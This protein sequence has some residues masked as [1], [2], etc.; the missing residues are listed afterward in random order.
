MNMIRLTGIA[1]LACAGLVAAGA[2]QAQTAVANDP[3]IG[4]WRISLQR[5]TM[6]ING[7]GAY[8]T[9]D[10]SFTW[11]FLPEGDH[12]RLRAYAKFPAPEPTRTVFVKPDGKPYRCETKT[13]CWNSLATSETG[14][15][16]TIAYW[17]LEPHQWARVVWDGDKVVESVSLAVSADGKVLTSVSWH[18]ET[19]WLQNLQVFDKVD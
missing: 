4:T 10:P 7:P 13:S 18:P 5:T 14:A 11:T 19:P 8:P 6:N 2:A 12:L 9:R 3:F 17:R 16:E 15:R 1:A